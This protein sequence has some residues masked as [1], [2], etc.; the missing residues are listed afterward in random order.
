MESRE[1]VLQVGALLFESMGQSTYAWKVSGKTSRRGA[2][3]FDSTFMEQLSTGLL[4][5]SMCKAYCGGVQ[6]GRKQMVVWLT[7]MQTECS[8]EARVICRIGNRHTTMT[9][10]LRLICTASLESR[11]DFKG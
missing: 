5:H 2:T 11:M 6:K 10:T 4:V 8:R 9:A 3:S 7:C 1:H